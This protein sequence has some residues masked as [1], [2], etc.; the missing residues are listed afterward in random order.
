MKRGNVYFVGT[1]TAVK[2]G[3][4]AD[5]ERRL[6]QLQTGCP[7]PIQVF[8]VIPDCAPPVERVFHT[9]L[10]EYRG[11]GEWFQHNE[12]LKAIIGYV[13]AGAQPRTFEQVRTLLEFGRLARTA[14]RSM[15]AASRTQLPAGATGRERIAARL[16]L[17]IPE[18]IAGTE[19]ER[20]ARE[21]DGIIRSPA[22]TL[23][24]IGTNHCRLRLA[25]QGRY[26]KHD[27]VHGR[28]RKH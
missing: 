6:C 8:A 27:I 7:Y 24:E 21:A 17:E 11:V 26:S 4:A 5:V 18:S 16:P 23:Q 9:A 1:P 20:I 28:T 12:V 14:A 2:I 3:F 13:K 19:F 22:A 10:A 15:R 25:L